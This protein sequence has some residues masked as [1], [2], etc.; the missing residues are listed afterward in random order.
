M[1]DDDFAPAHWETPPHDY[2]DERPVIVCDIDG[3]DW[4]GTAFGSQ[5]AL[6][7]LRRHDM[8]SDDE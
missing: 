5:F 3:C 7:S 2:D 6:H 8:P 4:W 1:T